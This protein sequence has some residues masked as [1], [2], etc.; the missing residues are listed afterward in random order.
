MK[1][2][3]HLSFDNEAPE[4]V[5]T[6]GV[7]AECKTCRAHVV[8]THPEWLRPVAWCSTCCSTS[9]YATRPTLTAA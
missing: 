1:E 3:K 4:T 8:I 6:G 5:F 7:R 9:I 2:L